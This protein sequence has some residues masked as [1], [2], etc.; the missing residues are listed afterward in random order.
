MER[1]IPIEDNPSVITRERAYPLAI[2]AFT[3]SLSKGTLAR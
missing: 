1:R 2:F 3:L